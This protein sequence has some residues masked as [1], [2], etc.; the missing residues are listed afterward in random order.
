[1]KKKYKANNVREAANKNN[2]LFLVA[3]PRKEEGGK[4]LVTKK[5]HRFLKL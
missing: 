3:R 1:M 2:G 4:G 5:K